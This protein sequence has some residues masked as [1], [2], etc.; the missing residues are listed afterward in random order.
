MKKFSENINEAKVDMTPM[1]DI[2]FI[3]LIFFIVTTSFIKSEGFEILT[4]KSNIDK[5]SQQSNIIIEIDN[6]GAVHINNRITDISAIP[7][8]IESLLVNI[9]TSTVILTPHDNI[10]YQTIVK[11]ID[12]VKLIDGLNIVIGK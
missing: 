5:S 9:S 2:V 7:S 12:Q 3:L 4:T 6:R 10:N 11:V 8:S 1:L